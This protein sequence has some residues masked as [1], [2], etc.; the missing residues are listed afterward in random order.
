MYNNECKN[1]PIAK[2]CADCVAYCYEVLGDFKKL[3]TLCDMHKARSLANVYFW[4]KYF[5]K[6]NI[7]QVFLLHLPVQEALKYV[8]KK[9][10]NLLLNLSNNRYFKVISDE[11]EVKNETH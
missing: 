3:T 1:C 5:I 10:L 9:E 7:P 6:Y 8:S 11:L 2:G 4:N